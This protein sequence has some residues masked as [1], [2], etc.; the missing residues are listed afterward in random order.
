MPA[1]DQVDK[2]R[3]NKCGKIGWTRQAKGCRTCNSQDLELF[4]EPDNYEDFKQL[5]NDFSCDLCE[6]KQN[7]RTLEL[8][9]YS[10]KYAD[11]LC[12]S[13][14][15]IIQDNFIYN[16]FVNNLNKIL[17]D[18][19]NSKISAQRSIGLFA[20]ILKKTNTASNLSRITVEKEILKWI[21]SQAEY[22]EKEAASNM[23]SEVYPDYKLLPSLLMAND[24]FIYGNF[25]GPVG[26]LQLEEAITRFIEKSG[27]TI[28]HKCAAKP[29]RAYAK[30]PFNYHLNLTEVAFQLLKDSIKIIPI[31]VALCRM[32]LPGEVV[33][34]ADTVQ[35]LISNIVK[36]KEE[37]GEIC[38][39]ESVARVKNR[40]GEYPTISDIFQDMKNQVIIRE[41][42]RYFI[43]ETRGCSIKEKDVERITDYLNNKKVIKKVSAD[44]WWI[45]F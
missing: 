42:C 30:L 34:L 8:C 1:K 28:E 22:I 36:L 7:Y 41:K 23:I 38:L 25:I 13:A 18:Y 10:N 14:T 40:T 2:F 15:F 12:N 19:S 20:E 11:Q 5:L 16:D 39:Y 43:K 32:E 33:A 26:Y 9:S 6:I 3:C 17:Q 21:E 35:K 29:G 4:H 27:G 37:T 44:H 45:Q 24:Q 31:V